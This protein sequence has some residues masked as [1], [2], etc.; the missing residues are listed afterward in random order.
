MHS[1]ILCTVSLLITIK[2]LEEDPLVTYYRLYELGVQ[3]HREKNYTVANTLFEKALEDYHFYHKNAINCRVE[4][5][6]KNSTLEE[7][8]TNSRK[9]LDILE[10]NIFQ[11]FIYQ[12]KCLKRCFIRIF[13]GRPEHLPDSNTVRI[14]KDFED[15][16][17]YQFIQFCQYEL[18]NYPQAASAAFT[19]YLK[20]PHDINA[21]HNVQL[22]RERF[23]VKD[24]EITDLD[25]KPYQA[26]HILGDI[27]YDESN[28][29]GV[30]EHFERALKEFYE[31]EQR[32]RLQCE[33]KLVIPASSHLT[34][35]FHYFAELYIPI[36]RCQVDCEYKLS[37][38]FADHEEG[39]LEEHYHY[40]QYAYY[41]TGDLDR[42]AEAIGAFL[43]FNSSHMDMLRNRL[44]FITRLGYHDSHLSAR[45]E[46]VEYIEMR[47]K[48]ESL[49]Q[50][51]E[52]DDILDDFVDDSEGNDK[53]RG[54]YLGIFEK[55][56]I[57]V[58]QNPEELKGERFTAEGVLRDEQSEELLNLARSTKTDSSGVKTISIPNAIEAVRG[59]PDLEISLRLL[60]KLSE[61]VRLF[62]SRFYNQTSFYTKETKLVCRG[63]T[64]PDLENAEDGSCFPQEDGSCVDEEAWKSV[65]ENLD[66]YIAVL[67]INNVTDGGETVFLNR[68]NT[69][70]AGVSPR[71][72]LFTVFEATDRHTVTQPASQRCVIFMTFALE[73]DKDNPEYR[74]AMTFLNDLDEDRVRKLNIDHLKRVDE[75]KHKGVTIVQ[76]GEELHGEERFVADGLMNEGDCQNLMSLLERGGIQG[77]GYKGTAS[78]VGKISPHTKHEIF[79]GLTVGRATQLA[80]SGE[81]SKDLVQLYLDASER[82]RLLVENFFNLTRPLYFDFTHLVCRKA[83]TDEE[84]RSDLSHPVHA[85]NCQIQPD[86]SCLR[87]F[88]AYIARDYSAVLYLNGHEDFLGGEFFFAHD[89]KTEQISISPKCG[90]MVGFNAGDYHGV[91]AVRKGRR[92]AIAMWYTMDPNTQELARFQA[93]KKMA[94]G[95][96]VRGRTRT[97]EQI[98]IGN[99]DENENQNGHSNR[100]QQGNHETD[101]NKNK[102]PN[103]DTSN[104]DEEYSDVIPIQEDVEN[105]SKVTEKDKE[106]QEKINS[107]IKENEDHEEL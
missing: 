72:G 1:V 25:R 37:R 92:C 93:Q 45:K 30:I 58:I 69:A 70:V 90:R 50:Y 34:D 59:D 11:S 76:S 33:D 32:C 91:K 53:E 73:K 64:D 78:Q 15:G 95:T 105:E 48:L 65:T 19:Y 89:N 106:R 96:F 56:G 36:L 22:Y 60:L 23:G 86:G 21:Q 99:N 35:F 31:E 51:L 7:K 80:Q 42:A 79:E 57:K 101:T 28:W 26:S 98:E 66:E 84:E 17:H 82:A 54:H 4:C 16:R 9:V 67:F 14:D 12:S 5:R 41:Q 49:L 8:L 44:Y 97:R 13:G 68:K 85:D 20:H 47:N 52:S 62:T 61:S 40:L 87:Q 88:P 55:L 102:F 107:E 27:A 6:R 77:D 43:L 38:V 46:A 74:Q 29:T 2:A 71:Q 103:K 100:I 104:L 83:V 39:F 63:P 18:K 10:I 94:D 75:L 3:H 24:E 81:L